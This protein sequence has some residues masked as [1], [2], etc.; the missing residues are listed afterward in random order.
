MLKVEEER[1]SE[2]RRKKR[3]KKKES[4]KTKNKFEIFVLYSTNV[5]G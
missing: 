3:K 5:F 1:R 4:N 2:G